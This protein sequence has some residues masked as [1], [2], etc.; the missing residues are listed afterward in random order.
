MTQHDVEL[1]VAPLRDPARAHAGSAVYRTF[2]MPELMRIMRGAYRST[3]LRTP[4]RVL[5]G[6]EDPALRPE[7]IGGYKPYVDDLEVEFVK[8]ASHFIADERPDVVVD[9]ALGFFA[10]P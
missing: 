2:I 8:G 1:F 7:F 3:R 6:A 5:A 4:T 9:R 10:K